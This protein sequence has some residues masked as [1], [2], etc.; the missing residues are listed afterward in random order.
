MQLPMRPLE[1]VAYH[2]KTAMLR[3]QI[4]STHAR[5]V[6]DMKNIYLTAAVGAALVL[7]F[8][9]NAYA[10]LDPGTGSMLLQGCI[11]AVAGGLLAMR[12]SWGKWKSLLISSKKAAQKPH[13]EGTATDNTLK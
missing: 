7:S 13:A 11:A 2:R 5:E 8:T 4:W 9:Q 3:V 1:N 12:A 10:Y 6:R